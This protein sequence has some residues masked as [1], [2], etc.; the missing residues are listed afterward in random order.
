LKGLCPLF[1]ESGGAILMWEAL[2][3]L[4]ISLQFCTPCARVQSAQSFNSNFQR[5]PDALD[6]PTQTSGQL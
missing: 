4:L 3:Q 2:I 1:G 5:E 6:W